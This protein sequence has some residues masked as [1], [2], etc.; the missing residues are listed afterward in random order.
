[1]L[2][3]L[4]KI[5]K[6]TSFNK[7]K[8]QISLT[9]LSILHITCQSNLRRYGNRSI[10][11]WCRLHRFN[12]VSNTIAVISIVGRAARNWCGSTGGATRCRLVICAICR[13]RTVWTAICFGGCQCW[14][15]QWYIFVKSIQN[16]DY[17][18]TERHYDKKLLCFHI[19]YKYFL[20]YQN[21]V[22]I[23]SQY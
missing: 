19:L 8:K 23:K 11:R 12:L 9:G 21:I 6:K 17:K 4:L 22:F 2:F 3:K 16:N 15:L 10:M 18:N 20:I 13:T 1:M 7:R 5:A 14:F